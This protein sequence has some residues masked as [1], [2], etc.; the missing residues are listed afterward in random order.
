MDLR[1]LDMLQVLK[2]HADAADE[3]RRRGI[4]RTGN[5][6]A[7]DYAEWLVSTALN[8]TLETNSHRG[9]DATDRGG[10]RY[11]IKGRRLSAAAERPQLSVIRDLPVAPFDYLI[12]VDFDRR[13]RVNYAAQVPHVV[14]LRY[15]SF[16]TRQKGHVVNFRRTI[17]SE[18]GVTDRTDE[19]RT[20]QTQCAS[21]IQS[22]DHH[23]SESR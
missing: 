21:T 12:G 8:L 23:Q 11:E 22:H 10:T 2:L 18:P 7:G 16:S 4:C 13:Y 9:Y 3:L 20:A 5:S 6:P 15:A 1:Q 17:L 19:L 14:V